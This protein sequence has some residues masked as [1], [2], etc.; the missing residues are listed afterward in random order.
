MQ[1]MRETSMTAPSQD[2]D[3]IRRCVERAE[4]W[5]L[6]PRGKYP[7]H[8]HH[9]SLV[10]AVPIDNVPQ[11]VLDALRCQLERQVDAMGHTEVDINRRRAVVWDFSQYQSRLWPHA[12]P[13]RTMNTLRA[14]DEFYH[15]QE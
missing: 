6:I 8:I 1:H 2:R 13:D 5:N 15:E 3:L 12:G 4:G 7:A 9:A 10:Q 14:I 11:F